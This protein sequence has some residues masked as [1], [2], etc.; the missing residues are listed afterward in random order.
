MTVLHGVSFAFL[1]GIVT[2]HYCLV[3]VG[4]LMHVWCALVYESADILYFIT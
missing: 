1:S 2:H 4:N 3:A